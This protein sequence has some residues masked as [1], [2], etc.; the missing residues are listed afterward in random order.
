MRRLVLAGLCAAALLAA[1]AAAVLSGTIVPQRGMVRVTLGM[2]PATVRSILGTPPKIR[3]ASNTFGA[4]S[5]YKYR[6][7]GVTFQGGKVVAVETS[8][9][10]VKTVS[11]VGVGSTESGVRAGVPGVH[12]RTDAG[13]RHCFLG[14]FLPGKR[15]TDF[16]FKKG[17]VRRVVIGFVLD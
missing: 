7:V 8:S 14:A 15:V 1:P 13:V 4:Y 2:R 17:L 12:C 11:G 6:G 5:V 3:H 10:R 16:F 9:R